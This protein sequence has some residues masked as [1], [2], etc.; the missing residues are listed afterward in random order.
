M[1]PAS[2]VFHMYGQHALP[3]ESEFRNIVFRNQILFVKL[4]HGF[5]L[6]VA[7]GRL[8]II[9]DFLPSSSF[10]HFSATKKDA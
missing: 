7:D 2:Y 1:R 4:D 6:A 5:Q 3:A 8:F 10:P 9:P